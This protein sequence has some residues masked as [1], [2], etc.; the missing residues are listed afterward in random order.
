VVPYSGVSGIKRV[1]ERQ[2]FGIFA[3]LQR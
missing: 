3:Q 1:D 2:L